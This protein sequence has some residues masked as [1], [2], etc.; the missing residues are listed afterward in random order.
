MIEENSTDLLKPIRYGPYN[1]ND[2]CYL[3]V[4]DEIQELWKDIE[5]YRIKEIELPLELHCFI[6]NYIPAVGDPDLMLKVSPKYS[7]LLPISCSR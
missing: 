5:K 7:L 3:N 4:D 1:P 6:P 2:Y